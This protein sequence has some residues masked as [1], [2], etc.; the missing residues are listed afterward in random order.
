MEINNHTLENNLNSGAIHPKSSC[1]IAG[2]RIDATTYAQATERI[3]QLSKDRHGGF[4]CIGNT[5]IAVEAY[6]HDRFRRIINAADIVTSDGM[7][8]VWSLKLFGVKEAQRV[9]GY[10]LMLSV[11][12]R[13]EALGIAVGFYGGKEA[14]RRL[15]VRKLKN[16]FPHLT[17]AYSYSPPFRPLNPQEDQRIVQDIIASGARILFIGLGCPKQELWAGQHRQ[18]LPCVLITVGAAFDYLAGT[19]KRAPR[20]IQNLGLEWLV[21]LMQNPRRLLPRYLVA[22]PVFIYLLLR[23]LMSEGLKKVRTSA[24]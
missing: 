11:L 18:S 5:H 23:Q 10:G 14:I 22:N 21:R 24:C 1:F 17:V 13:A 15:M 9:V 4:I 3:T 8:L 20:F 12:A 16:R 19:L 7:P 2:M 6:R